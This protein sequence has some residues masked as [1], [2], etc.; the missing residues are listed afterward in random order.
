MWNLNFKA[1]ADFR[2]SCEIDNTPCGR[3]SSAFTP[4]FTFQRLLNRCDKT[5]SCWLLDRIH[6][7]GENVARVASTLWSR[8]SWLGGALV[9]ALCICCF[10]AHRFLYGTL[11]FVVRYCFTLPYQSLRWYNVI[12][13]SCIFQL[14]MNWSADHRPCWFLFL[15]LVCVFCFLVF[16]PVLFVFGFSVFAFCLARWQLN[17]LWSIQFSSLLSHIVIMTNVATALIRWICT[18]QLSFR[19]DKRPGESHL[20]LDGKKKWY[21]RAVAGDSC[22]AL[23]AQNGA[24]L[25]KSNTFAS[26]TEWQDSG[27]HGC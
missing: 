24:A 21:L 13:S 5:A 11:W 2:L 26:V 10:L 25:P 20:A 6:E 17:G 19:L 3:Y 15:F 8:G 7:S 23:L 9:S 16:L 4:R 18:M 14:S 22:S 27:E 12:I 1:H